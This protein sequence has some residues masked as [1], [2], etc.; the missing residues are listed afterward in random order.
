VPPLR[1][2]TIDAKS[3]RLATTRPL[4]RE[5]ISVH[6]LV[7]CAFDIGRQELMSQANVTVHVAD[8][9]DN[10]P[11]ISFPD[12][13]NSTIEVKYINKCSRL[14]KLISVKVKFEND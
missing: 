8:R 13:E 7:L 6:Q 5:Q 11:V 10:A 4:D 9:N 2:F 1:A 3:G 14:Y 12:P